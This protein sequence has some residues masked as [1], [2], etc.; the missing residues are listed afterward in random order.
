MSSRTLRRLLLGFLLGTTAGWLAGLL[1]T[2]QHAPAGSSAA[3]AAALPQERFGDAPG[4][5]WATPD[6]GTTP[7]ASL[8]EPAAPEDATESTPHPSA[9]WEPA[10]EPKMSAAP[11]DP[12]I[13]ADEAAGETTG[14][15]TAPASA[16]APAAAA[17]P[18]EAARTGRAKPRVARP[19]AAAKPRTKPVK[20]TATASGTTTGD[21]AADAEQA[22]APAGEESP[23]DGYQ[24]SDPTTPD[25]G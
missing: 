22:A 19:R 23:G 1:R 3:D 10:V 2:P 12:K 9:G 16:D 14:V 18:A 20:G 25:G 21:I 11:A 6:P 7:I 17:A 8:P 24:S 5:R 15:D 4:D 13:A